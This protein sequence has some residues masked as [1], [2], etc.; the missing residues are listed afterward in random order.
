[1]KKDSNTVLRRLLKDG[2]KVNI[3]LTFNLTPEEYADLKLSLHDVTTD[4]LGG[5]LTADGKTGLARL[6]GFFRPA[7]R[8]EI[9]EILNDEH[10]KLKQRLS[11]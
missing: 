9:H 10:S 4:A 7:L 5:E 1:M 8:D 2:K 11:R 6:L 3:Q